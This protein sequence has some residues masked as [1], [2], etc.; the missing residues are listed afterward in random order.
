MQ[1]W[2]SGSACGSVASHANK[3]KHTKCHAAVSS[4]KTDIKL[5]RS[6]L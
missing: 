6:Q 4:P 3:S 1:T 5:D 2:K